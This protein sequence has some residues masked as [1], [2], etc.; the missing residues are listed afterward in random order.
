MEQGHHH[1]SFVLD[2]VDRGDVSNWP[3]E[4]KM[5]NW[6]DLFFTYKAY[7]KFCSHN[8]RVVWNGMMAF[9]RY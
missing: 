7:S 5:F 8:T 4:K 3:D 9:V 6:F 2:M 1:N